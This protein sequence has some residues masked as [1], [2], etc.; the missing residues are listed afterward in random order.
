MITINHPE[1]FVT[2]TDF[3]MILRIEKSHINFIAHKIK[4][5]YIASRSTNGNVN[6]TS[7]T[8]KID[9]T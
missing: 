2:E 5:S 4:N 6:V 8:L 9:L 1:I 7:C 3:L